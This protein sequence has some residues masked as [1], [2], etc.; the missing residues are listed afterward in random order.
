MRLRLALVALQPARPRPCLRLLRSTFPYQHF[1]I[2]RVT[3]LLR[4]THTRT[5][6]RVWIMETTKHTSISLMVVHHLWCR[7]LVLHHRRSVMFVHEETKLVYHKEMGVM[8]KT[9]TPRNPSQV[10]GECSLVDAVRNPS[11]TQLFPSF[12]RACLSPRTYTSPV[13]SSPLNFDIPH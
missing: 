6:L 9:A 12:R 3:S 2:G 11:S 10:S 5:Q 7:P 8:T 1:R 4:N 13:I